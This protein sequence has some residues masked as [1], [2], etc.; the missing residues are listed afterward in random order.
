VQDPELLLGPSS[1]GMGSVNLVQQDQPL[2]CTR[3]GNP[4]TRSSMRSARAINTV[5][6]TLTLI[7]A[8]SSTTHVATKLQW[9][10]MLRGYCSSNGHV[11]VARLKGR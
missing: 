5:R 4:L 9:S 7:S 11:P 6:S 1:S 10:N 3:S 2:L 8:C